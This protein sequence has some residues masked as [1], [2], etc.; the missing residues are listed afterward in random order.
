[1]KGSLHR[2]L[3]QKYLI[4]IINRKWGGGH[5]PTFPNISASGGVRELKLF[6][7]DSFHRIQN[8]ML[9]I[10]YMLLE[11]GLNKYFFTICSHI[12]VKEC[13]RKFQRGLLKVARK[14]GLF[15]QFLGTIDSDAFNRASI[16]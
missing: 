9:Y 8:V 5:S 11:N 14:S 7:N 3:T 1:M 12:C 10:A 16:I 15:R 6:H 2:H 13:S 4:D